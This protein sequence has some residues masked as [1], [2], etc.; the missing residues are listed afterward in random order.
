MKVYLINPPSADPKIKMIREGRC[1]QRSGTWTAIWAPYSL[2]LSAAV[3]DNLDIETK[4]SDCVVEETS[5]TQLE[6]NIRNFEPDAVIINTSTPSLD[7]DLS[8]AKTAKKI[9]PKIL[10][11][12][13]GIH[14]TAR[15]KH[16][17][18]METAVDVIIRGEIEV[19]IDEMFKLIKENQDWKKIKGIS[20]RDDKRVIAN[21]DRT[22]LE[23]LDWLP[24]PAWDKVNL[25]HYTVPFIDKPFLL[26]GTARG[27]PFKCNFCTAKPYYGDKLRY[28]SAKKVVDE[29]E[30][31]KKTLGVDE[32][33]IWTEG[34]T[35]NNKYAADIC[36]EI[37]KRNVK[38]KF[39]CN[40]RVDSINPELLDIMKKAG[41]WMIGFGI[42]NGNQEILDKTGKG[43]TIEQSKKAV[44]MTKDAG[45]EVTAHCMVGL[46]G[47]TIATVKQTVKLCKDMDV[48]FA[49]FYIVV[50][51]WWT[52]LYK[53]LKEKGHIVSEDYHLYEQNFAVLR[54]DKMTPEEITH[55]R[56]W[57]YRS[58]YI[59][60]KTVLRTL[61]RIKNFRNLKKFMVMVKDFLTWV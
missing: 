36:N 43:I 45:I 40:S 54:T 18:D 38:I 39:V 22:P 23:D 20:F 13:I 5:H 10:T 55:W 44:K 15:P 7:N 28:R 57:A 21:P 9:N 58:F 26:L 16:C 46:P 33:L 61:A 50:P 37:I 6:E 27:C 32:F 11:V 12:V 19:T 35:I 42:E 17:F 8:V 41:C 3:L 2:C 51:M 25:K 29:I 56:G 60:P 59:R 1:M 48:E 4:V 31:I 53:E 14:P 49:Q 34:F 47:E 30:H 24:F 52:P